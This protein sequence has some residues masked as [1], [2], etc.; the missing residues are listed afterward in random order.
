MSSSS[1]EP[2]PEA[3]LSKHGIKVRD[4][5]HHPDPNVI[6]APDTSSPLLDLMHYDDVLFEY[7]RTAP[8]SGRTLRRLLDV[9]WVTQD[10]AKQ[11]WE[12]MDWNSLKRYDEDSKKSCKQL[13]RP[14]R[15]E[16]PSDEDRE[17][18]RLWRARG[19]MMARGIRLKARPPGLMRYRLL[20]H[21]LLLL[22]TVVAIALGWRLSYQ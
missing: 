20:G 21:G 3:T 14:K 4:F 17:K 5:A 1:T 13:W 11:D 9:G 16:K 12:E 7:P 10:E 18:G 8:V 22:A 19:S 15:V 2:N 6:P